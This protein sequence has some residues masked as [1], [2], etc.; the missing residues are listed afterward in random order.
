M[1]AETFSNTFHPFPKLF[2][3][4]VHFKLWTS[5]HVK[6]LFHLIS[7]MILVCILITL[8][9]NS[10]N[11]W[12]VV[13]F[14][15]TVFMH[16]A[17]LGSK[18][19]GLGL[20][21][22]KTHAAGAAYCL[23]LFFLLQKMSKMVFLGCRGVTCMLGFFCPQRDHGSQVTHSTHSLWSQLRRVSETVQPHQEVQ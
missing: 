10:V 20:R 1:H 5:K 3:C 9:I 16:Q 21:A 13:V 7:L 19:R 17:Q 4:C 8:S 18:L 15:L 23:Q 14:Q 12:L 11:I 22:P 2:G 6:W